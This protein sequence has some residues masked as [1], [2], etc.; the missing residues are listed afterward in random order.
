MN[1]KKT[2]CAAPMPIVEILMAA[3][4]VP[5]S[6]DLKEMAQLAKVF[7]KLSPPFTYLPYGRC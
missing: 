5:A 7:T 6:L 2:T 3:I 1:V 4:V